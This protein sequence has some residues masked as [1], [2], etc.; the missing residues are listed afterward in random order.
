MRALYGSRIVFIGAVHEALPA[1]SELLTCPSADV[2]LVVTATP[3]GAAARSGAVDLV[4]PACRERVPVLLTDDAN[5]PGVVRAIRALA[6]DLVVVI[7]WNQSI[8]PELLGIPMRGCVGFQVSLLPSLRGHASVNWAILR[9][10]TEVVNTMMML[11]ARME[12]GDVLAQQS[13]PIGP[14][15]TC[16][17]VHRHVGQ[18]GAEMLIEHLP[19]LIT[20][21]IPRRRQPNGPPILPRRT[22]EMGVINWDQAP[23]AVHDWVRALTAPYPGAFTVL[24]G[25][26]V[27]VW[28][29]E[30]PGLGE[31]PAPAGQIAG[32][33]PNGVRI[34]TGRGSILVTRMSE[35]G[36]PPEHARRWYRRGRAP[37]GTTFDAVPDEVVR[38]SH[39]EGR[40]PA[41][42]SG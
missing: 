36:R 31:P 3:D 30:L 41:A 9:G 27:M 34:G 12:A 7:G 32:L 33:E 25:R 5:A 38:W 13:V 1:L 19:E 26:R 18:A 4:T 8:R 17:T 39:G 28:A 16:A 11:E 29:T 22:P 15:D 35:A 20:G 40:T 14:R 24:D 2:V 23:R 42:V 10:E 6:P 37:I 21:T